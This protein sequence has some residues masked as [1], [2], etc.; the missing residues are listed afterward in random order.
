MFLFK[1]WWIISLTELYTAVYDNYRNLSDFTKTAQLSNSCF[2]I[3]YQYTW[4][5]VCFLITR[6]YSL[7]FEYYSIMFGKSSYTSENFPT[8]THHG[9]WISLTLTHNV[10]WIFRALTHNGSWI[11]PTLTHNG[12]WIF[13]A[14]TI[15]ISQYRLLFGFSAIYEPCSVWIAWKR[16]AGRAAVEG[17]K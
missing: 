12:S 1:E 10:S 14:L 15:D 2:K 8:M 17:G 4:K 5:C 6:G 11:F 7:L 16:S 9:S 3:R 13:R